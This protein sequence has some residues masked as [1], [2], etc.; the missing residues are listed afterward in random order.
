METM[1]L[2]ARVREGS[3]KGPARRLRAD[4]MVPAVFY[5]AGSETLTLS[6]NTRELIKLLRERE[7]SLFVKLRIEGDKGKK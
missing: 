6:V 3:G 5:G 7:E 2:K 4:G 1:E